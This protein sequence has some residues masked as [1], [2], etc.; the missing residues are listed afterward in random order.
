MTV[1]SA[2]RAP[3]SGFG[4]D[5]HSKADK[6]VNKQNK[7]KEG[8]HESDHHSFKNYFI[9]FT[10]LLDRDLF[11]DPLSYYLKKLMLPP[12]SPPLSTSL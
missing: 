11:T 4:V 2:L 1:N 5:G 7:D 3:R 6:I 8:D 12:L 9:F 10:C